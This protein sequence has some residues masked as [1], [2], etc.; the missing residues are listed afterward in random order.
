MKPLRLPPEA[1]LRSYA[2]LLRQVFLFLRGASHRGP[3]DPDLQF[4]LADAL[5][6]VSE[7]LTE[8]DVWVDDERFRDLYLRPFDESWSHKAFA[9]E[10]FLDGRMKA[11]ANDA[12]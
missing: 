2:D 10:A 4:A 11:Y 12:Q 6:N 7:L 1:V 3:I 8:Y 9:L 5:H